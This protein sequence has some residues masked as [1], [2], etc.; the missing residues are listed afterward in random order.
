MAKQ[1]FVR[2]TSPRGTFIHPHLTEPDMKFPK[3]GIGSYHVKLALDADEAAKL[4]DSLHPLLMEF[5]QAGLNGRGEKIA[6]ASLKKAAIAAI[7]EEE[8]DEDGNETGRF[9]FKFKLPEKVVLPSGKSWTLSPKLFDAAAKPIL[10][11]PAIWTGSEGKINFEV[12]PYFM[13]T[14]KTFGLSLRVIGVQILKLV[15]GGG[16]NAADMGFGAEE[17]YVSEG[18][19]GG[20]EAEAEDDSEF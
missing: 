7:G 16:A 14:S 9:I 20:F 10:D 19:D 1:N 5:V 3:N 13:E 6:P 15:S 17:G 12:R 2:M 18:T 4:Q 8:F 11:K